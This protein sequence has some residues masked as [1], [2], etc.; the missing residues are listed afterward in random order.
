MEIDAEEHLNGC[1]EDTPALAVH[2]KDQGACPENQGHRQQLEAQ[3]LEG[4]S[5]KRGLPFVLR[6]AR[7]E[8][9]P[10]QTR[11]LPRNLIAALQALHA[12]RYAINGMRLFLG[13][14]RR[15]RPPDCRA[16]N[17]FCEKRETRPVVPESPAV[18]TSRT[19]VA[20]TRC[21]RNPVERGN[22][23]RTNFKRPAP[24]GVSATPSPR[25]AEPFDS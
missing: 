9:P 18:R 24:S 13:Y 12:P 7:G 14:R 6:S 16:G 11:T 20:L 1:I 8:R 25:R 2:R 17:G 4:V 21:C 19:P 22:A 23:D 3:H 15:Q 10:S 5:V